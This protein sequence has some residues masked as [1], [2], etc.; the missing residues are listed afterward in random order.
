MN[1]KE[2]VLRAVR[3]ENTDRVPLFYRDIPT[4]EQRLLK[5]LKLQNRD[6]LLKYFDIDFRWVEP[7][8]IGPDLVKKN[9]NI[10]DIWGVEYKYIKTENGCYWKNISF[11][12]LESNDPDMLDNYPWP[13]VEWFDFSSLECQLEKY[14]NYAIM[15]APG[16]ASPSPLG[17]TQ[18]LIGMERAMTD[19]LLNPEYFLKLTEKILDFELKFIEKLFSTTDGRI[20]FFRIGDDFGT[21][22]GL[23][24]SPQLWQQFIQPSLTAM[25]II[26][27]QCGAYYYHHSCGAVSELIPLLIETGVDVLDPLQ[28][29]AVGMSPGRLKKDFGKQICFSG[30]VDEQEVLNNGTP[31]DVESHVNNLLN[32]MAYGGGFII[33]PTHNFQDDIPTENIVSMYRT[34]G[35]WKPSG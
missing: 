11:P 14:R 4:V 23:L 6:E 13:C 7:L 9:G 17:V 19:M 1:N 27:K 2:R 12:L 10:L 33:G 22:R 5:D 30:G 3:H 32:I 15:T 8:Y 26:A 28:V 34:A 29:Q 16:N 21:Q 24:M 35:A 25:S 20:D 18:E 31:E